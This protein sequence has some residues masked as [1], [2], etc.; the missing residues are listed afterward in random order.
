MS[1]SRL[2]L[3]EQTPQALEQWCDARNIARYRARQILE[4][5]FRHGAESFEQMTNLP[6][7]LREQLAT[8]AVL[9]ESRVRAVHR[10]QDGTTKLLLAWPDGATSE[11]VLI[12]DRRRRT[13]CLSTQVGCP[14]GCAFCASGL[15]GLERNLSAGQIVEQAM[16]LRSLCPAD[17]PL[18]N[19]V[20][21]GIGE[22]LANYQ[23]T[24]AAVR[25]INAEWG[26]NIGAR[27]ITIST[28]GLPSKIRRLAGEKLQTTLA[29]SLHAPTDALRRELIPWAERIRLAELLDAARDYF[30]RTGRE[31]T[32][33]Y[34]LLKDIN[35]RKTHAQ[36]L[37]RLA[38]TLRCH[39]NLIRYN[40]VPG[41]PFERPSTEVVRAF[42]RELRC[43]G[44][45]V[46]V[47]KSRG[48][49]IEAACGQ[50][51][52]TSPVGS[53]SRNKEPSQ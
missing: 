39:V 30:A 43:G 20:F 14:V 47:R 33:E 11:C 37:A 32:I 15:D 48:A 34:V 41:L 1:D 36:Q 53:T 18:T 49:D 52:R 24:M 2:K 42:C 40:A 13:A 9:Y 16:R 26:M 45:N 31:V 3:F 17:A 35:D 46:H 19:V 21:M 44:I 5:V 23:A 50:L 22:P 27:R 12:P 10:A 8:E 51:R 7:V 38:K 29:I 28:I 25:T 4:W 6:K